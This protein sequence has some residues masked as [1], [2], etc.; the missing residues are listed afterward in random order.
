MITLGSEPLMLWGL[1]MLWIQNIL[2]TL[3]VHYIRAVAPGKYG[4]AKPY[5]YFLDRPKLWLAKLSAKSNRSF[6]GDTE[7][8]LGDDIDSQSDDNNVDDDEDFG[9]IGSRAALRLDKITKTYRKGNVQAL[10]SLTASFGD[11]EITALLGH[12]GAGK[13]KSHNHI[14]T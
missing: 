7:L 9:L 1:I 12:N 8:L 11:S 6:K 10:R 3:L 5:F 4:V 13:S 14:I 2:F